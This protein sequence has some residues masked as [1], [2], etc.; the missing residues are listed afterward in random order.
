MNSVQTTALR[1]RKTAPRDWNR[2]STIFSFSFAVVALTLLVEKSHCFVPSSV[3]FPTNNHRA[4]EISFVRLRLTEIETNKNNNEVEFG[5]KYNNP[6]SNQEIK[7][8]KQKEFADV[9]AA[10]DTAVA[11]TT[12]KYSIQPFNGIETH[13]FPTK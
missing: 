10:I 6:Y 12:N 1:R 2:L 7:K 8:S 3:T 5:E 4:A 9:A 11:E 13:Q